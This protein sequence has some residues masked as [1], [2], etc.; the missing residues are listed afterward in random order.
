[1]KKICIVC[2]KEFE[3]KGF[4][5]SQPGVCSDECRK[6][7]Q[8]QV[9]EDFFRRHP[10]KKAEYR[11]KADEYKKNTFQTRCK[12]CGERIFKE[13]GQYRSP[14]L[15]DVCVYDDILKTLKRHEKLNKTQYYR[16]IARG[17]TLG[18]FL[19]DYADELRSR[20]EEESTGISE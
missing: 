20:N 8:K 15:H 17:Y 6:V 4:N 3:Y 16:L 12:I 11:A 13:P 5:Y 10:E 14:N 2:G 7:R 1:M 9:R 18:E 19:K